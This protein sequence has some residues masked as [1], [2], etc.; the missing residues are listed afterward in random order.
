VKTNVLPAQRRKAVDAEAVAGGERASEKSSSES[1][2]TSTMRW[3]SEIQASVDID[4]I[5]QQQA[6]EVA[7]AARLGE[8]AAAFRGVAGGRSA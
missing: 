4:K 3:L 1:R 7:F 8:I 6:G 5:G 2:M